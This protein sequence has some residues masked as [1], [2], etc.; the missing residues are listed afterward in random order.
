MCSSWHGT[1]CRSLHVL[2]PQRCW[3]LLTLRISPGISPK[4]DAVP[5]MWPPSSA[6]ARPLSL[7]PRAGHGGVRPSL[8]GSGFLEALLGPPFLPE[9]LD[10]LPALQNSQSCLACWAHPPNRG[11][12]VPWNRHTSVL[13][14]LQ[15]SS[16]VS[17][18]SPDSG[19]KGSSLLTSLL[20]WHRGFSQLCWLGRGSASLLPAL[21]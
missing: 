20:S 2:T 5:R 11:T 19:T 8:P 12:P 17:H 1:C 14:G 18:C 4:E 15:R 13:D 16:G 21:A 6:A 10:L 3:T 7:N 9:S